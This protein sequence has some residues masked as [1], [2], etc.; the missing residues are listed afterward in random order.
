MTGYTPD[1]LVL[2]IYATS[3]GF[4]FVLFEGPESPFDWGVREIG[5]PSR[6]GKCLG[7]IAEIVDRYQPGHIVI[8]D[9]ADP[10]SR[11]SPRIRFL[12]QSIVS[13][14]ERNC[15]DVIRVTKEQVRGTFAT[16]SAKTKYEIAQAIAMRIPAFASRMPP[17]RRPWM[18]Q[19][20]R[21]SLFDA[22]AIALAYYSQSTGRAD[23]Q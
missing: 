3:R 11:R 5:N 15:I 20:S 7:A 13:L 2:S 10:Y 18:S 12:Y 6:N 9:T 14:A 17:V 22:V 16:V 21:Q 8:E 4:A 19:D 23:R 1:D